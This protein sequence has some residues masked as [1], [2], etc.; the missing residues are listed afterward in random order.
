MNEVTGFWAGV[1]H[2]DWTDPNLQ[3][4]LMGTTLL[5]I[6]AA[7]LGCFAFLRGRSLMGDAL[8]HA[9]LPG[10][11]LAFMFAEWAKARGWFDLGSKDLWLLLVGASATGLLAAWCISV[12]GRHSRIKEDAAQ[13][14]VLSVFFGGGIVLLTKILHSKSG[15]QGG[16][17]KFLFGQAASMI[18]TDVRTMAIVAAVLCLL[19][20]ALYKEL[21]L[22]CFD[23][24]FGRGLGLPM[25]FL[26]GLLL[27]MIVAAVVIGL[28][29]VGVVL[30]S[31]MLIIPPAAARFWSEKLHVMV[32]LAA[33][34]GGFSGALG[35]FASNLAPRLP[36]GP[37][38]VLAA[39]FIFIVSVLFAPQRGA[40]ARLWRLLATRRSV[41]R[42][43][44]LRDLF[45]LTEAA[46]PRSTPEAALGSNI[47]TGQ[48]QKFP[49]ASEDELQHRRRGSTGLLRGTLRDLKRIKWVETTKDNRWRLTPAGL[50]AAYRVVRQH[51][52][53]EMFLMYET[54]L[55]VHNVDRDADMVE[56]F[57]P[58]ETVAQLET[59]MQEHGLEPRLRPDAPVTA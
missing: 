46:L 21:K 2:T 28:Q 42:E 5:G 43:N 25:T 41:Q 7:V 14:I 39:T 53:W 50:A 15:N 18:D 30:I 6:A 17:E 26:D 57:L 9:A 13:A 31:A 51:R 23:A 12:I 32:P 54:S 36:T 35:T 24:D 37:M 58:P 47:T 1:L 59:M 45:E 40:L 16:L 27:T 52:L 56:H 29:A 20:A 3:W 34:M 11:C 10:V 49:G 22:L 19:A 4:V 38:I 48:L 44:V 8:A 55:G 33:V